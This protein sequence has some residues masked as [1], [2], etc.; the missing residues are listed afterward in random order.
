MGTIKP[1]HK[2]CL[3]FKRL[4]WWTSAWTPTSASCQQVMPTTTRHVQKFSRVWELDSSVV[5]KLQDPKLQAHVWWGLVHIRRREG[6][7]VLEMYSSELGKEEQW[8]SSGAD[9][10][11]S[12]WGLGLEVGGRV[13]GYRAIRP[14]CANCLGGTGEAGWSRWYSH[15]SDSPWTVTTLWGRKRQTDRQ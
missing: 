6:R 15:F 10:H 4:T 1:H 7:N 11:L 8:E 14:P 2:G 5:D 13:G 12:A 3:W 9:T